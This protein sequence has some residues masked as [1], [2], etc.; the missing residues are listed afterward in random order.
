MGSK[1][2][3]LEHDVVSYRI[4]RHDYLFFSTKLRD[5]LAV[6]VAIVERLLVSDNSHE[7]VQSQLCSLDVEKSTLLTLTP[8]LFI[9]LYLHYIN[10]FMENFT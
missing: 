8:T 7:A 2:S 9:N 4:I 5:D 3:D 6:H 1:L 10:F